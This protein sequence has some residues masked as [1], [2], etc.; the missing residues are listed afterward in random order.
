MSIRMMSFCRWL[1]R[2]AKTKLKIWKSVWVIKLI[3][4]VYV[5]LAVGHH[6]TKRKKKIKW[7]CA[8]RHWC[9]PFSRRF[10]QTSFFFNFIKSRRHLSG[11]RT[12][13]PRQKKMSR[14][15]MK[16][17]HTIEISMP[18]AQPKDL[19]SF[20]GH[21]FSWSLPQL[22]LSWVRSA[23]ILELNSL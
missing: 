17:R 5:N 4:Y 12:H 16:F 8:C 19:L 13:L 21:L 18:V 6:L 3:K 22:S 15:R 23:C 10:F 20:G 9:I 7:I 1:F 2:I 11:V 14:N